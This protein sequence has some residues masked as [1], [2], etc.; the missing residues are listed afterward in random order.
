ME[1]KWNIIIIPTFYQIK[2]VCFYEQENLL[3]LKGSCQV[4]F[5]CDTALLFQYP[6]Q[7]R[8]LLVRKT[9]VYNDVTLVNDDEVYKSFHS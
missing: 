2:F 1:L 6:L 9:V 8:Q 3:K 7:Y 5:T 4:F